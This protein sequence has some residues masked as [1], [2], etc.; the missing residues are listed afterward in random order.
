MSFALYL[1]GIIL[2]MIGVVWALVTAGV[3]AFKIAIICLIL[4]GI[5]IMTGVIKTRPK[6]PPSGPAV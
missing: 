1:I 3:A 2:I 4:F 6:D 5:G